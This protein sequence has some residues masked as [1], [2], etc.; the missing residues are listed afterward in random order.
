MGTQENFISYFTGIKKRQVKSSCI[1]FHLVIFEAV[2]KF[3]LSG[4]HI[5][6]TVSLELFH[7]TVL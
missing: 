2:M 6:R 1:R 7:I 4:S 3:V 5:K